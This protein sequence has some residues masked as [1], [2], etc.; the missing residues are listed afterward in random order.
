M[1]NR[2]VRGGQDVGKT[3]T[4][5]CVDCGF[6]TVVALRGNTKR[7]RDCRL[8]YRSDYKAKYRAIERPEDKAAKRG[9]LEAFMGLDYADQLV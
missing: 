4:I 3:K 9:H 7:C 1:L 6:E 8:A 5:K 2:K